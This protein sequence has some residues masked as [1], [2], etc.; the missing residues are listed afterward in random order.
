MKTLAEIESRVRD[1]LARKPRSYVDDAIEFAEY[2][3]R[4]LILPGWRCDC[5]CFNGEAKETLPACRHCG[6]P[7]P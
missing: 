3:S 1:V 5:G 4:A 6:G 2:L 7:R